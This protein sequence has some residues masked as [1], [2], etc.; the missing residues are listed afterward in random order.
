MELLADLTISLTERI[1]ALLGIQPR[2]ER[3][4]SLNGI[5]GT[6]QERLLSILSQFSCTTYLSGP[7]AKDYI[8]LQK[9]R[10]SPYDLHWVEYSLA[11]YSRGPY[12]F[13]PYLS[14]LD[15]LA[16]NGHQATGISVRQNA[17]SEKQTGAISP[18]RG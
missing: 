2:F 9:W 12:E 3:A 13:I 14:V 6:K 16:W 11:A 15:S 5:S 10:C 1:C 17:T 18:S 8:D 4:S 7:A